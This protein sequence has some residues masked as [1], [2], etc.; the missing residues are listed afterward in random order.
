[1]D[2]LYFFG[3]V[4]DPRQMRVS[5]YGSGMYVNRGRGHSI[6]P[7]Y[8][9]DPIDDPLHP[10]NNVGR[11]CFRIHQCVKA[12]ADAHSTLEKELGRLSDATD[13]NEFEGGRILPNII[14][15][16]AD[17]CKEKV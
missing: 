15:S 9:D 17:L 3:C 14:P 1:M 6:D 10:V 16:I 7:L 4:F 8:I 2:F 12:F 5:I 11:N 13:L